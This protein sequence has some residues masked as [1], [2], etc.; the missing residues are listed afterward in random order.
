VYLKSLAVLFT[1]PSHPL[2]ASLLLAAPRPGG[3]GTALE[4]LRVLSLG[5]E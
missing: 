5:S 4:A 1:A 3:K 2:T